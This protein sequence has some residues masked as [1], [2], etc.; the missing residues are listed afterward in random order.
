M[1]K[2]IVAQ[3]TKCHAFRIYHLQH[4]NI[5]PQINLHSPLNQQ[6]VKLGNFGKATTSLDQIIWWIQNIII[7]LNISLT[8]GRFY[9]LGRNDFEDYFG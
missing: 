6:I 3:G 4:N 9:K 2:H 1:V 5:I 8:Y 7:P